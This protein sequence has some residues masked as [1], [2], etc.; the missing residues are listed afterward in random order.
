MAHTYEYPRAAITSDAVILRHNQEQQ[1]QVLLIRRQ[2]PPFRDMWSLPGGFMDMDET[3]EQ[4]VAREVEEET[5]LRGISFRQAGA[6]STIGR[7]PRHRTV[8]VSFWGWAPE[9]S[10]PRAG[11]DSK[12]VKW[13]AA[14]QLPPLAFDHDQ[15]IR[16]TLR[17]VR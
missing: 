7:D 1:L 17:Q 3:L 2:N 8:T 11:S 6:Y 14:D 9:K 15:I 12:E 5:G 10:Q 16:D 4:C 13:F